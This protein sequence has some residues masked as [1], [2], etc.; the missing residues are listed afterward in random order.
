MP[1]GMGHPQPPWATC[2]SASYFKHLQVIGLLGQ[3]GFE[4][5]CRNP[6]K[7]MKI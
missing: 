5:T 2:S 4:K 1:P 3:T 7:Q 6:E